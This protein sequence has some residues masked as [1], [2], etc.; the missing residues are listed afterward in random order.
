MSVSGYRLFLS[1][2]LNFFTISLL[3][4]M[5][6]SFR[7][8]YHHFPATFRWYF[9][10]FPYFFHI[11]SSKENAFNKI[12]LQPIFCML[13]SGSHVRCVLKGV[14]TAQSYA[15]IWPS[16]LARSCSRA[17]SATSAS[18]PPPTSPY[19]GATTAARRNT[20]VSPAAKVIT[21]YLLI[22]HIC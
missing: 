14:P 2:T 1:P 22:C 18:P 5:A 7:F 6:N 4:S 20:C 17:P 15:F 12:G 10:S 19:T 8:I 13:L 16:T 3:L 21:N 9:F 11:H